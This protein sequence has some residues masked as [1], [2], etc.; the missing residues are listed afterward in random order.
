[1]E[2]N[3]T[4]RWGRRSSPSRLITVL[5]FL[6][7]SNIALGACA[8]RGKPIILEK[9]GGFDIGGTI[10]HNPNSTNPNLTLSCDHGYIE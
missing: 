3:S 7:L 9:S 6:A 8:K 4:E 10:I 5:C 1:M 2:H